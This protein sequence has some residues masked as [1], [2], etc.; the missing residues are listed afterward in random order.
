M[1][2]NFSV[3]GNAQDIVKLKRKLQHT[4]LGQDSFINKPSATERHNTRRRTICFIKHTGLAQPILTD[5]ALYL[6]QVTSLSATGGFSQIT[7]LQDIG[8]NM[9]ALP[10]G[11]NFIG[12]ITCRK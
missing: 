4:G 12:N 10:T 5:R 1:F 8:D 6:Q 9:L 11:D 7:Y 3:T 2:K